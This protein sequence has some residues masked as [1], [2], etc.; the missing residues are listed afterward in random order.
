LDRHTC[1]SNR[2]WQFL[3]LNNYLSV[4]LDDKS[5]GCIALC[6][7]DPDTANNRADICGNRGTFYGSQAD[8]GPHNAD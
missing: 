4:E 8:Y 2:K 1:P 5:T 7:A 3:S 6:N